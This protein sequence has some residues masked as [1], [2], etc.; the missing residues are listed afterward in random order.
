MNSKAQIS[1]ELLLLTA[2]FLGVLALLVPVFQ[3]IFSGGLLGLEALKAQSFADSFQQKVSLLNVLGNESELVLD[4]FPSR[5]WTLRLNDNQ[6]E[7]VFSESPEKEKRFVRE[8]AFPANPA[9]FVLSKQASL[10][11]NKNNGQ[12]V[13]HLQDD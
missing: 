10:V 8:L 13:V 1:L 2:A 12:L 11:L 6:L 7:I 3:T 9:E 4:V 5:P